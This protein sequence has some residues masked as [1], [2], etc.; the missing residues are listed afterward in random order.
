ML[1]ITVWMLLKKIV[2]ALEGPHVSSASMYTVLIRWH[3][4]HIEVL[5]NFVLM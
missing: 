4:L 3:L 2:F 1:E 5:F